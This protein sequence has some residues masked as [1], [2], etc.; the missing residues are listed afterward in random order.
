LR[1]FAKSLANFAFRDLFNAKEC[2]GIRKGTPSIRFQI[3]LQFRPPG[4]D[5]RLNVCLRLGDAD[6]PDAVSRIQVVAAAQ[7]LSPTSTFGTE[8]GAVAT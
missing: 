1:T 3:A 6:N 5:T 7:A 2:K 4:Y 8:Q